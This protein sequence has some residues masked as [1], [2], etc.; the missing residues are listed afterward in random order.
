MQNANYMLLVGG[1]LFV[2]RIGGQ[3]KIVSR[4]NKFYVFVNENKTIM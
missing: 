1:V 4:A 3:R 2:V